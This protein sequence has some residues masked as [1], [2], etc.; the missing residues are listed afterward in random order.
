MY[1][2]GSNATATRFSGI[3]N[4]TV[5]LKTYLISGLFSGIAALVMIRSFQL[6]EV[7][8]R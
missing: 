7:G 2:I 5:L 3:H 8:I 6:C 1:M 4:E